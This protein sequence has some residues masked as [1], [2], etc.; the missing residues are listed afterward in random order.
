MVDANSALD[1]D[2]ASTLIEALQP[3]D[4][5]WFEEPL[6]LG[7][8]AEQAALTCKSTV[9]ICGNEGETGRHCVLRLLD[10]GCVDY[11]QIDL[12]ICGGISAGIEFARAARNKGIPLTLHSAASAVLML[13]NLHLAA[14]LSPSPLVESHMIHRWLAGHLGESDLEVRDGH[15]TP[16]NR[17]GLGLELAPEDLV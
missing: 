2:G 1:P 14:A 6:P 7:T 12:S 4:L 16:P 3:F 8:F 17:P 10:E 9:P 5:D 15:I 11:L 13:S